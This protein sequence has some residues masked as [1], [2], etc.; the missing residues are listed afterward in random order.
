MIR[1]LRNSQKLLEEKIFKLDGLTR[2]IDQYRELEQAFAVGDRVRQIQG[3]LLEAL[4]QAKV[5]DNHEKLFGFKPSESL[6]TI[7]KLVHDFDAQ[8]KLWSTA[9]SWMIQETAWLTS[10]FTSL[11]APA[12]LQAVAASRRVVAALLKKFRGA[13]ENAFNVASRLRDKI[14]EFRAVMPLVSKLRHPGVR[15]R[16]WEA[17]SAEL[18]F[19][20]PTVEETDKFTLGK[21]IELELWKHQDVIGRITDVA[22]NEHTLESALEKMSSELRS[23]VF[24]LSPYKTTGT[25]IVHSTDDLSD[26]VEDQW[27]R[28]QTMLTS[29]YI[30]A[31]MQRATAWRGT[32]EN[33]RGTLAALLTC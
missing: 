17:F 28:L 19:E 23:F 30:D 20:L 11:N 12:M 26:A 31:F 10:P 21:V 7:Q 2:E 14:E 27:V 22:I 4:E 25:S 1:D 33:V 32:L 18:H 13:K 24:E 8:F 15:R 5:F 6:A 3:D 29:P 9:S 16:H